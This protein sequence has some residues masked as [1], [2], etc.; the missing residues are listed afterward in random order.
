MWKYLLELSLG[1]CQTFI[2]IFQRCIVTKL[3]SWNTLSCSLKN[4][5]NWEEIF[6]KSL[7]SK[8][9]SILYL[10]G[11]PF[12]HVFSICQR[13]FVLIL[14]KRKNSTI[15]ALKNKGISNTHIKVFTLLL[16]HF[17][18]FVEI[19]NLAG[20]FFLIFWQFWS[21][22]LVISRSRKVPCYTNRL[23]IYVSPSRLRFYKSC[24]ISHQ[25]Q[26]HMLIDI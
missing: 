13:S 4:I 24:I 7:D 15:K 22:S 10:L 8:Y 26:L 9:F 17:E 5:R 20:K 1:H 6:A 12:S 23:V 3:F 16:E 25:V 21:C 18:I 19:F 11:Q 14:E 2:E